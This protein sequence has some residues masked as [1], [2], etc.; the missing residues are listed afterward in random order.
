MDPSSSLPA[1]ADRGSEAVWVVAREAAVGGGAAAA[2]LALAN[3]G[4][5][6]AIPSAY[7]R[8]PP[9][10]KRIVGA[11]GVFGSAWVRAN[12]AY[13]E[14]IT[15]WHEADAA[16]AQRADAAAGR[17]LGAS[18]S[19]RPVLS[20]RPEEAARALATAAALS[21]GGAGVGG[22]YNNLPPRVLEEARRRAER[23]RV[24]GEGADGGR[25]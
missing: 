9:H 20:S 10:L 18:T 19:P 24:A 4:L 1:R 3:F 25:Q 21:T 22:G 17:G 7:R 2:A 6:A 5:A 13:A 16:A 11:V 15:R 23:K 12:V 14:T 8:V